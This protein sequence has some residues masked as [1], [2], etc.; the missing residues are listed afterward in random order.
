V[1]ETGFF[2]LLQEQAPEMAAL[3]R[4]TKGH[5]TVYNKRTKKKKKGILQGSG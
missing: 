1:V 3:S 5:C 2:D 4:E